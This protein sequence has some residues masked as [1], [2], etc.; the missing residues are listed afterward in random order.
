MRRDKLEQHL[1]KIV[2]ITLFDDTVIEGELHKTGEKMF[3]NDPNLYYPHNYYFLIN[4]GTSVLF[5]CSHVKRL[6]GSYG[7]VL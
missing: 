4:R 1:G 7:R 3:K 5:R 6:E 2:K